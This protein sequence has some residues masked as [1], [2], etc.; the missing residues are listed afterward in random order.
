MPSQSGKIDTQ[1]RTFIRKIA[2]QRLW[3]I[4]LSTIT[5]LS[6][7]CQFCLKRP[8]HGKKIFRPYYHGVSDAERSLLRGECCRK[9]FLTVADNSVTLEQ[10]C[11]YVSYGL[12]WQRPISVIFSDGYH[13]FMMKLHKY[14]RQNTTS[15]EGTRDLPEYF[16]HPPSPRQPRGDGGV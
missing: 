2:D 7:R 11:H 4:S 8:I 6:S 3:E 14:H 5:G 13:V 9:N 16:H 12:A 10:V 15:D 1:N